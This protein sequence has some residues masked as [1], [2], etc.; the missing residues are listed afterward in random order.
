M[1][2]GITVNTK[3]FEKVLKSA[4][5]TRQQL[6]DIRGAGAAVIVNHQRE[7]VPTDLGTTKLS[8]RSHIIEATA[9]RVEDEVGPETDYAPYLEYGTGIFAE[10]GNGRQGGWRYKDAK[11]NWHFTMGMKPQPFIRPSIEGAKGKEVESAIESAFKATLEN[12]N[13]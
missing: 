1:K 5:F 6:L 8:I 9:T 2:I 3:Q 12:K 10:A 13:V 7:L 11:G 4:K